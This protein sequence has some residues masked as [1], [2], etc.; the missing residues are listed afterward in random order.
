MFK[1][2]ITPD[3][4]NAGQML[5]YCLLPNPPHFSL[6]STFKDAKKIFFSYFYFSLITYPQAHYLYSGL[7]DPDP[8]PGGPKTCVS[9][10]GFG[11]PTLLPCQH[12]L[13]TCTYIENHV[14]PVTYGTILIRMEKS[15]WPWGIRYFSKHL[16]NWLAL[17]CRMQCCA[18]PYL[19]M[20]G[21]GH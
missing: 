8:D 20:F 10:S 5:I 1:F 21:S 15:C 12:C 17:L 6:P 16:Q 4:H 13:F 9:G 18:D 7:L 3:R 11:S 14:V 19:D 2:K